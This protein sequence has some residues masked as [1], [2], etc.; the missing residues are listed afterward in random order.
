MKDTF[1][2]AGK[3][4]IDALVD[5][6]KSAA[7]GVYDTVKGV[8]KKIR[9]FLPFSPAKVGPLSDLD[10]L[11]F[12]GPISDAIRGGVPDVQAQMNS[13]LSVPDVNPNVMMDNTAGTTVIMQLDGKTIAKS[14]FAQMGGVFRVRGA[15]T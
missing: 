4:F 10:K 8:A 7:N 2:K 11:D 5:G 12:G 13:M 15:V 6:I 14:T 3:G 1:L 9:D